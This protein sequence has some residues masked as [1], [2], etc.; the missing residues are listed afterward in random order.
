MIRGM[1][2]APALPSFFRLLLG[3]AVL[4]VLHSAAAAQ[5]D[6]QQQTTAMH[7]AARWRWSSAA[8]GAA[9]RAHITTGQLASQK[10][11]QQ[12]QCFMQVLG[13]V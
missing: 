11:K 10:Q 2:P 1:S 6:K 8:R 4:P 9:Y 5:L 3:P 12:K 13:M 7:E